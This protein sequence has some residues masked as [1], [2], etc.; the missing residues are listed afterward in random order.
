M[1]IKGTR[2]RLCMRRCVSSLLREWGKACAP[3]KRAGIKAKSSH[4]EPEPSTGPGAIMRRPCARRAPR[5]GTKLRGM[6]VDTLPVTSTP[7]IGVCRLDRDKLCMGC[8]RTLGEIAAWSRL[9]E[10]ERLRLMREVLPRRRIGHV[11]A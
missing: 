10:T 1:K 5:A 2:E 11:R 6:S 8:R 9:D 3:C 4:A 7:C